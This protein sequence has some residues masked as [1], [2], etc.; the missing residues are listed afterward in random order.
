MAGLLADDG[1][2]ER[3]GG[4][5]EEVSARITVS[6]QLYVEEHLSPYKEDYSNIPDDK[7]AIDDLIDQVKEKLS[8][9]S[10]GQE[11]LFNELEEL[12]ELYGKL[13]KKNWGELLKGKLFDLAL[14]R[15]ISKE[16][17]MFIF[18]ALTG[19]DLKLLS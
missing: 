2:V 9:I 10:A 14:D 8:T 3:V 4:I 12:R 18:G 16:T 15:I 1:Y 19:H 11:V 7:A 13:S 17:F 6:G 5:G